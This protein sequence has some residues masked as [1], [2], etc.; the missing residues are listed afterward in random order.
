MSQQPGGPA[1]RIPIEPVEAE[2]L[3]TDDVVTADPDTPVA[4]VVAMLA[5]RDVGTVVVTE[6]DRPVGIITDRHI[7][8]A[9]EETPDLTE[10]AVESVME[11]SPV[12]VG[13]DVDLSDAVG[14]L[15]EH[16]IR[17]VPV[18]DDDGRLSGILS[19]DDVLV[20]LADEL[21]SAVDVIESQSP[22]Y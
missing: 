21:S 8:L 19:L 12:T 22:R 17:R 11:E 9:L 16:D 14:T 5:E 6:D 15:R 10:R 2:R 1:R 7:A 4:T 3:S 20:V 18:V 13:A